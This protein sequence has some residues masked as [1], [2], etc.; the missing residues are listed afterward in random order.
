M[1]PLLSGLEHHGGRAWWR[2]D[3]HLMVTRKQRIRATKGLGKRETLQK[4]TPSDLLPSTRPHF[5]IAIQL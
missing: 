5:L 1:I 4:H 3:L 2:K